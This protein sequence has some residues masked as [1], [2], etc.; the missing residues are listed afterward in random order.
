VIGVDNVPGSVP[1]ETY[2]LPRACVL[3]FGTESVGLSPEALAGAEAVVHI[4]QHGSTRSLNLGAAGAI[5]MYAWATR[6]APPP[7]VG[8]PEPE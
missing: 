8:P 6:W 7:A 5:A 1:I 3:L 4:T 2:P